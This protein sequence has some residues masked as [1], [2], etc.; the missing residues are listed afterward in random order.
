[1]KK[2]LQLSAVVILFAHCQKEVDTTQTR[3]LITDLTSAAKTTASEKQNNSILQSLIRQ[4]TEWVYTQNAATSPVYDP[5]GSWQSQSQ[6]SAS[7]V[8]MLAGSSSTEPTNRSLTISLRQ[9]QYIFVPLVNL[10]AWYDA[11]D[12]SFGPKDHQS[13][14]NFFKKI[15]NDAFNGNKNELTLLW[16][17]TSLLS[18]NQISLRNNSGAWDFPIDPSWNGGC[19]AAGSSTFYS[20]GFWAMIPL[21]LG[22]HTLTGGGSFAIKKFSFDFSNQVTYT[23]QVVP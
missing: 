6:P 13:P 16:D 23:I 8:F 1:M 5:D 21:T 15:M 22:T 18:T 4:W 12:P 14:E 3:P 10:S 9:Y 20:D 17:N 7:G 11:C 19:T 2:F